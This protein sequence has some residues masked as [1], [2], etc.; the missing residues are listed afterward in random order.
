M[1]D[2]DLSSNVFIVCQQ[3]DDALN[4]EVEETDFY[5]FKNISSI[6]DNQT[7]SVLQINNITNGTAFNFMGPVFLKHCF[8]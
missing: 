6:T 4:V 8:V 1:S 2:E 7:F 3:Q 5:N